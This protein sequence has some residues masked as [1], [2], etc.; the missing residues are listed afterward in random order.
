MEKSD[1]AGPAK[2]RLAAPSASPGKSPSKSGKRAPSNADGK[3]KG[4]VNTASA[5]MGK[6]DIKKANI[7]I[8]ENY[9]AGVLNQNKKSKH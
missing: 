5:A 4:Q 2:G 8:K 7:D 9:L 1:V 3:L 6:V